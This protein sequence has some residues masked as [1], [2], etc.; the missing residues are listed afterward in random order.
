VTSRHDKVGGLI[1]FPRICNKFVNGRKYAFENGR[2]CG[3][4]PYICVRIIRLYGKCA[5]TLRTNEISL[6]VNGRNNII[7]HNTFIYIHKRYNKLLHYDDWIG[8][9]IFIVFLIC[10][11]FSHRCTIISFLKSPYFSQILWFTKDDVWSLS[12][13]ITRLHENYGSR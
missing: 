9:L 3:Y 4:N 10:L 5:K 8:S 2:I 11:K 12:M 6:T 13:V 7:F 1:E